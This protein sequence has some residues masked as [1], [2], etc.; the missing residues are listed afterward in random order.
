MKLNLKSKQ[1]HQIPRVLMHCCGQSRTFNKYF[2]L[3]AHALC[4]ASI[5]RTNRGG[6]KSANKRSHWKWNAAKNDFQD[7]DIDSIRDSK[8]KK[9][10]AKEGLLYAQA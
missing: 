5:Q 1:Q 9:T 3:L 4:Q 6:R 10:I 7:V 8:E 2:S